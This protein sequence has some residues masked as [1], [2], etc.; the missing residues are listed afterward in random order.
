MGFYTHSAWTRRRASLARSVA[1]GIEIEIE[2]ADALG[3]GRASCYSHSHQSPLRDPCRTSLPQSLRILRSSNDR[4]SPLPRLDIAD[5]N[6]HRFLQARCSTCSTPALDRVDP[7]S[8][9][10][11]AAAAVAVADVDAVVI[12]AWLPPPFSLDSDC[13]DVA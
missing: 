5:E 6:D 1:A 13:G 12:S 3:S 4:P 10:V 9:I 11:A 7:S 8:P 2:V